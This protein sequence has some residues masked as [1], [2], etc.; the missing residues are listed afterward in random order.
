[1]EGDFKNPQT[2]TLDAVWEVL[3]N[4][5]LQ[6]LLRSIN[7]EISLKSVDSKKPKDKRNLF[8]KIFKSKKEELKEE[9]NANTV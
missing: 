2:N 1:L 6:A 8:Q 5:F 9:I 3:R 4:A 7:N